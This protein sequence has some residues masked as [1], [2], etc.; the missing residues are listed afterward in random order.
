MQKEFWQIQ[1][2]FK[3]K[4]EDF[5]ME[6]IQQFYKRKF[7]A[8][9]SKE[10]YL[11]L[12]KFVATNIISKASKVE[13]SKVLWDVERLDEEDLPTFQLTLYYKF[14]DTEFM[15]QTCEACKHFHKSFFIN[16]NF[17]CNRCNKVGYE[18]NL[19]QKLM[20]GSEYLRKM[21]DDELNR[22]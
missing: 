22:L 8:N 13:A 6:H 9:D 18:K 11:R 5:K 7:R 20:I 16:E 2:S 10:A 1:I 21:L 19:N 4:K 15:K 3:I 17:N 12:C 14:D